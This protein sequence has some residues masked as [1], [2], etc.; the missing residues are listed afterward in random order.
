MT[1]FWLELKT[2]GRKLEINAAEVHAGAEPFGGMDW[3]KGDVAAGTVLHT[4]I[5]TYTA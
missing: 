2:D 4:S 1:G 5:R 3:D